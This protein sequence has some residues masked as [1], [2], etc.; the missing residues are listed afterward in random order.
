MAFRLP[1][2]TDLVAVYVRPCGR[3]NMWPNPP[4]KMDVYGIQIT[5][6]EF[7]PVY[8]IQITPRP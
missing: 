6:W 8:G 7:M 5:P 2:V 1:P 3:V 4:D